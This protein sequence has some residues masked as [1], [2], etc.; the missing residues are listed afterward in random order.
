MNGMVYTR[1]R[2]LSYTLLAL[3][4]REYGGENLSCW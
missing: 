2:E 1:A 4:D 3:A